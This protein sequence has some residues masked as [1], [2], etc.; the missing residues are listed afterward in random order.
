MSKKPSAFD[1][2][3]IVDKPMNLTS[4]DVV[5]RLRTIAQTRQVGHAGTLDPMATGV[6][7]CGLGKA[8]KLL[9]R[10]ADTSKSYSATIRLGVSTSTDD[11]QGAALVRTDLRGRSA[12]VLA[13][14][15]AE[16]DALTGDIM[17]RPS[18]ISAIKVDGKRAY[19]RVR[20]GEQIDIPPRPVSVSR[21]ELQQSRVTE[22][23]AQGQ[24]VLDLDVVVDCSTGTYIRA[25][26]RDLGDALAVGGHLISLRRTAVG[27]F[28]SEKALTLTELEAEFSVVGLPESCES[29][30]FGITVDDEV[31]TWFRHGRRSPWPDGV[32]PKLTVAVSGLDQLLGL[33][34]C[35]DGLL[36]PTV[37]WSPANA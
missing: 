37:V 35:K 15:P 31:G 16:I 27:P 13:R 6:L 25:L 10:I 29:L 7:V 9:G 20:A 8:T 21:F 30:F 4:H 24:Q 33:A 14:V 34:E 5:A 23:P 12:E 11:A 1:G 17:Q 19:H 2:L 28:R 26:A 18:S 22:L 36:A 32:D 3:V